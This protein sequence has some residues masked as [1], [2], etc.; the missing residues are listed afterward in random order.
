MRKHRHTF[1]KNSSYKIFEYKGDFDQKS[2]VGQ[3]EKP[4][5]SGSWNN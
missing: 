2:L 1:Q 5:C 3:L 4:K